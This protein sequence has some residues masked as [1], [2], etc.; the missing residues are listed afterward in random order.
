MAQKA[1]GSKRRKVTTRQQ[2]E[3]DRRKKIDRLTGEIE[4][5]RSTLAEVNS[6]RDT[7]SLPQIEGQV[8]Y[9]TQYGKGT[10]TEQ[11]GAVISVSYEAGIRKQKLPFVITS[12]CITMEDEKILEDCLRILEL[13]KEQD[14]LRLEIRH[15]ESWIADLENQIARL[16]RA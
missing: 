6:E 4:A 11:R 8:V 5:L 9:H 13:E 12:G 15:K 7:L 3:D 2:K 1:D 14:R 10:V 16:K